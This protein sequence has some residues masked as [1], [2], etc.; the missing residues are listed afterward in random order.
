MFLFFKS[1]KAPSNSA[2]CFEFP[3]PINFL[4]PVIDT[5][6]LNV[7]LCLGP[8]ELKTLYIGNFL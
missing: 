5:A 2:N 4:D 7:G 8:L 6:I 1:F 3:E